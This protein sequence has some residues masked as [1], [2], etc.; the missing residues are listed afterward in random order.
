MYSSYIYKF[1]YLILCFLLSELL[2][3]KQLGYFQSWVY[4]LSQELIFYSIQNPLVSGFYRL[5]TVAMKIAKKIK[6]YQV[7]FLVRS[8]CINF[9]NFKYITRR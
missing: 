2:L 4:P 5:L 3:N 9:S 8:V 6:Y 7:I 1:T